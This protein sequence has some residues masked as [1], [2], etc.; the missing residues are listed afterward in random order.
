MATR[1][2]IA[3]QERAE[4][5]TNKTL[6]SPVIN[7]AVTGTSIIIAPNSVV[8]AGGTTSGTTELTII[9]QTITN[10]PIAG[11]IMITATFGLVSASVA[12]DWF[13]IKL[14]FGTTP[15]SRLAGRFVV[16]TTA[17]DGRYCFHLSWIGAVATTGTQ[18]IKTTIVRGVGTGVITAEEGI[19][20]IS[21]VIFPGAS[22]T[23]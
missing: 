22:A 1:F 19:N 2:K 12:N 11:Q 10:P 6:T 9:T 8:N 17:G 13:E 15:T 14:Y 21:W 20:N 18:I 3:T 4:T 23:A 5:F 16:P 7:G